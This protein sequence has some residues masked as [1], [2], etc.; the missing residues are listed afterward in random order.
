MFVQDMMSKIGENPIVRFEYLI[1]N[2]VGNP[3]D[4]LQRSYLQRH[5]MQDIAQFFLQGH[6]RNILIYN[7]Y[8]TTC[9]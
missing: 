9:K 1:F 7:W 3:E 5:D 4:R 6:C 2:Y 8:V